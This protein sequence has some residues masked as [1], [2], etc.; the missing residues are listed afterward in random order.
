MWG[1][2]LHPPKEPK[3][4]LV[5]L[6]VGSQ[7]DRPLYALQNLQSQGTC[8]D[9]SD[10]DAASGGSGRGDGGGGNPDT[11]L[12]IPCK[13]G[14]WRRS[15]FTSPSLSGREPACQCRRH[16]SHGFDPWVGKIPWR[17]TWQPTPG[18]L[19]GESHGQKSLAGYSPWGRKELDTTEAT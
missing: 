2:Q 1:T 15:T 18:F 13:G 6:C 7:A 10:S 3:E 14:I 16:R 12:E 11:N 17:R 8:P 19:P 5:R 9:P 4:P